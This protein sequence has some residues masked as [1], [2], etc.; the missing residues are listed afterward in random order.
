V[1]ENE[2]GRRTRLL[3]SGA[4]QEDVGKIRLHL[5]VHGRRRLLALQLVELGEGDF[6]LVHRDVRIAALAHR[7][8]VGVFLENAIHVL[9]LLERRPGL[10][11]LAPAGARRQPHGEGLGEVFV[12]M[13]L[14]VPAGDVLDVGA[15]EGLGLV[16]VTV[17]AAERPEQ[18]APLGRRVDP[19]GVVVGV[20]GLM[21]QVHHDLGVGLEIVDLALDRREPG[22]GEV[23]RDAD[24]RVPGRTA[25]LICQVEAGI[26]S[27]HAL[28]EKFLPEAFDET[29]EA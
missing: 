2:V 14:G 24:D 17:G 28:L 11:A 4:T 1:L 16:V 18:L 29:L 22:V 27:A 8:P 7:F 15:A 6:H 21:A 10:V 13:L 26:P 25:P 3:T 20:A 5:D 9:E 12:W 23:E 19:I